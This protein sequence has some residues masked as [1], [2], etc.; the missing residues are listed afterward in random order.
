VGGRGPDERRDTH[1]G[2]CPNA[3]GEGRSARRWIMTA[4]AQSWSLKDIYTLP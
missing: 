2:A 4:I 1:A 3:R